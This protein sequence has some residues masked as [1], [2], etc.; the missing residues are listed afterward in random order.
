MGII[1]ISGQSIILPLLDECNGLL[2]WNNWIRFFLLSDDFCDSKFRWR[3]CLLEAKPALMVSKIVLQFD[4]YWHNS[5][6]FI[7]ALYLGNW[8]L[9]LKFDFSAVDLCHCIVRTIQKDVGRK[10]QERNQICDKHLLLM[11]ATRSYCVI[12]LL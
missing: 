12:L 8:I 6:A 11:V 2:H 7:D 4:Y 9:G 3:R 5:F 1:S 10:F